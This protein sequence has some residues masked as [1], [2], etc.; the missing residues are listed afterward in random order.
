MRRGTTITII[1]LLALIFAAAMAQFF[2]R[3]GP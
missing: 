3:L 1:V 2:L